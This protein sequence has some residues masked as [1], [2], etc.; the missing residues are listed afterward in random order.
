[1]DQG[2]SNRKRKPIFALVAVGI[3]MCTLDG[4]IV[5]IALPIIMNDLTTSLAHIEWVVLIY[6]FTISSLLLSFGRLSDIKGRRWI[7]IRGLFLFTAGSLLCAMSANVLFLIL[8]RFIQGI[9][10]SM[11]M[12]CSPAIIM[13]I[14]HKNERGKALGMIGAVVALG[15]SVGPAL[16][17]FI[18]TWFSWRFI[19]YIN[20]PI[21]I[22]VSFAAAKLLKGGATDISRKEAFDWAGGFMLALCFG[23]LLFALTHG[24]NWGYGSIKFILMLFFSLASLILV[25][26]IEMRVKFPVI[27]PSLMKIRLFTLP[28]VSAVI[29]FASLFIIVFLMPFYLMYPGGYSV[30][31][32][33]YILVT[34]FISLLF[35]SPV[36]GSISDRI[37]SRL[38]CTLGMAI[39]CISFLCMAWLPPAAPPLAIAWRLALAGIGT[40]VFLSP[41]SAVTM[42]SA[43]VKYRG[44]A[45]AMVAMARNAGMVFGVAIAGA[46]FNSFFYKLSGGHTLRVYTPELQEVFMA[47]FHYAMAA[48]AVLSGIGIFVAFMRGPG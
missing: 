22:A 28:V 16:G 19:F 4:S 26:K 24:Y 27:E 30:K 32:A 34:L 35:V 14:F 9:G 5:N 36:A 17:G 8:S 15:L 6:L 21:G 46:I 29:I 40:A 44:I 47:A 2:T 10:A 23:S 12:A 20:I 25:V 3:F 43:P 13:D 41:N 18:L 42:N 11:I 48:G 37:G 7:Q 33:G 31:Q 39:L 38:L 1:M 45:A